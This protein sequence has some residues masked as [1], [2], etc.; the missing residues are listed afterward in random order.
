MS[1]FIASSY[2]TGHHEVEDNLWRW[3]KRDGMG[4]DHRRDIK[5][6]GKGSEKMVVA[7]YILISSN[8]HKNIQRNKTGK[9]KS[10]AQ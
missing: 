10:L 5:T 2:F 9:P 1:I 7:A 3:K 8:S 4:G 6:N